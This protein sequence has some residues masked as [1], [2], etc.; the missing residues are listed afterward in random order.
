MLISMKECC[1]KKAEEQKLQDSKM[2][3]ERIKVSMAPSGTFA[4]FNAKQIQI[5]TNLQNRLVLQGN[6]ILAS[7]LEFI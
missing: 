3:I 6:A 7:R 4:K 1:W 5:Q 2:M